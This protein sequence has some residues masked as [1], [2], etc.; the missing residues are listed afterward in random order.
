MDALREAAA[1]VE[2][3]TAEIESVEWGGGRGGG[4]P[5]APTRPDVPSPPLHSRTR[6]AAE[7][8]WAAGVV[9]GVLPPEEE[10][11]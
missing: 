11:A 1:A 3:E 8:E 10:E 4:S 7:A 2:A 6:C 5:R 9:A